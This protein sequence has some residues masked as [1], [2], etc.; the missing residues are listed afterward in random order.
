MN[1]PWDVQHRIHR[2]LY[3]IECPVWIHRGLYNIECPVWIHR[4]LYNIECPVWIH[5]SFMQ[6]VFLSLYFCSLVFCSSCSF[7]FFL[8]SFFL[9]VLLVCLSFCFVV[10][11]FSLFFPFVLFYLTFSLCLFLFWFIVPSSQQ[12]Y[13]VKRTH[14]LHKPTSEE[15]VKMTRS[16]V[17]EMHAQHRSTRNREN[18]FFPLED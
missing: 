14:M 16:H 12:Q 8:H 17:S 2:G 9:P 5:P 18:R 3:N 1:S 10:L 7:F 6:T 15:W 11:S 13:A 4:G